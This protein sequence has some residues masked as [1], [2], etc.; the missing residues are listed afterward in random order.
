MK[1]SQTTEKGKNQGN[2]EKT[3]NQKQ[4]RT[5]EKTIVTKKIETKNNRKNHDGKI[6]KIYKKPQKLN[7]KK[8]YKKQ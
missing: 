4:I 7:N 6:P 3:K 1:Q 8:A 2:E 5:N